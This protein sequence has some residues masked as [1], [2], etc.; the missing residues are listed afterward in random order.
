MQASLVWF[1]DRIRK[2]IVGVG[3]I[4]S[5]I[6]ANSMNEYLYKSYIYR[7]QVRQGKDK[8][9]I[10]KNVAIRKRREKHGFECYPARVGGF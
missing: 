4:L 7:G 1:E 8:V 6:R 9:E 2:S 10:L 3:W 5:V